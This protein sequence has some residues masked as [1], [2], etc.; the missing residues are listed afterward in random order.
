MAVRSVSSGK[1]SQMICCTRPHAK[2]EGDEEEGKKRNENDG[3]NVVS[4]RSSFF[5]SSIFN[6]STWGLRS[7]RSMRAR[8]ATSWNLPPSI[9]GEMFFILP[10]KTISICA[11]VCKSW[12]VAANSTLSKAKIQSQKT[13]SDENVAPTIINTNEDYTRTSGHCGHLVALGGKGFLSIWDI[14]ETDLSARCFQAEE[15]SIRTLI[16]TDDL[17]LSGDDNGDICGWDHMSGE[18]KFKISVYEHMLSAMLDLKDFVATMGGGTSEV[19]ILRKSDWGCEKVLK[20]HRDA[21]SCLGAAFGGCM[22]VLGCFVGSIRVWDV[23][24]G[25]CFSTLL[26]HKKAV[27]CISSFG[28]YVASGS[29]DLTVRV[30]HVRSGKC[31]RVLE[32]HQHWV[33]SISINECWV[34]SGSQDKTVRVWDFP[35]GVC[36]KSIFVGSL[37]KSVWFDEKELVL[38]TSDSQVFDWKF[39]LG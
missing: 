13:W 4:G 39:G 16:F 23:G 19:R 14:N 15:L 35:A 12:S 29:H 10:G 36:L 21:V 18:K 11:C 26:G 22:I 5:S 9:L 28:E 38:V 27:N 34:V 37:P 31:I 3:F 30:W 2:F 25:E 6:S 7:I 33:R 8:Q 20:G 32:G 17:L 1:L 24:L